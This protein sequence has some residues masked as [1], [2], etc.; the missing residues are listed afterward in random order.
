[1][2]LGIGGKRLQSV[3]IEHSVVMR[4]TEGYFVLV[5]S[6]FTLHREGLSVAFSPEEDSDEAFA[7]IRQLVGQV[8]VEATADESGALRIC[9]DD[10]TVLRV[11]S[12]DAYEAWN[13][14]GPHGALVVCMPGGELAVWDPK[15]PR[16]EAGCRPTIR[17]LNVECESLP[18]RRVKE[19]FMDA[20]FGFLSVSEAA[21]LND[22]LARRNPSL[23][24]RLTQLDR[25]SLKQAEQLLLLLGDEFIDALDE[26][27]EPTEYG[28]LVSSVLDH[29]N[30]VKIAEWP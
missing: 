9:V 28:K 17:T 15:S 8:I 3:L 14:S 5:A 21:L 22:V 12:D 26:D 29:V 18:C 24:E 30:A 4:L 7:P 20:R 2:N 19:N 6:P 23:L 27:W 11:P 25:V 10:G 16:S 13:L 1:M